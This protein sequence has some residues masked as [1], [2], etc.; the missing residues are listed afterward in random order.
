MDYYKSFL[1]D[2]MPQVSLFASF[3]HILHFAVR[4]VFLNGTF[5]CVILLLR[6]LRAPHSSQDTFSH[7]YQGSQGVLGSKVFSSLI[8]HRFSVAP[9]SEN[10]PCS[11]LPPGLHTLCVEL[12]SSSIFICLTLT[13]LVGFSLDF[14]PPLNLG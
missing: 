11:L 14:S 8:S 1:I 12:P 2:F 3:Q 4:E 10:E 5:A 13:C 9:P 7:P 6:K